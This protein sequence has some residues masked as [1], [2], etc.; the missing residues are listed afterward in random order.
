M[1]QNN[2]EVLPMD[3]KA[4]GYLSNYVNK[5]RLLDADE[6]YSDNNVK[7]NEKLGRVLHVIDNR[8]K[9]NITYQDKR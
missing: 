5:Y 9:D 7:L 2:K 8:N 1:C 3:N 6:Q 4:S